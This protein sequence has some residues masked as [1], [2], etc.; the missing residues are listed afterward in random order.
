[1]TD[2]KLVAEYVAA[3]AQLTAPL[4]VEDADFPAITDVQEAEAAID[5]VVKQDQTTASK[6]I[7]SMV[8]SLATAAVLAVLGEWL[9]ATTA[10]LAAGFALWS[11]AADAR[12]AR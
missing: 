2:M 4:L 9:P 3:S 11:K 8:L 5:K 12:P 10:A 1:M 7:W 6:R